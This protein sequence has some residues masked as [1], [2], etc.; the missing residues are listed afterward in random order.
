[1][2]PTAADEPAVAVT[3]LVKR[4]PGATTVDGLTLTAPRGCVTALLGPNGAGKTTTVECCGGYRR[5]RC[6]DRAGG[7]P[8]SHP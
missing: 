6:R 2:P 7:R 8:R 1:M 3:G 4:Y 5:R